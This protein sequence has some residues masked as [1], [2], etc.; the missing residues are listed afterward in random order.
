MDYYNF[1]IMDNNYTL[2]YIILKA[3]FLYKNLYHIIA[4]SKLHF[5]FRKICQN[6]FSLILRIFRN[7]NFRTLSLP[8]SNS[9]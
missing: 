3:H 8:E 7:D 9:K 5:S 1:I 4:H 2:Y 6:F